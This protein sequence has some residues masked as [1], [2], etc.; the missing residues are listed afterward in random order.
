MITRIKKIQAYH[1]YNKKWCWCLTRSEDMVDIQGKLSLN[2]TYGVG[3]LLPR[4][5][6]HGVVNCQVIL[7]L[8]G[9]M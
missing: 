9:V 8:F 1:L 7:K 2:S 6:Q 4:T 5:I 3:V